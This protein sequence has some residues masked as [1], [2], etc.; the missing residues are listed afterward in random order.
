VIKNGDLNF[1][2]W[3]DFFKDIPFTFFRTSIIQEKYI[4]TILDEVNN[5]R[6]VNSDKKIKI[7]EIAGGSG[8]TSAVLQDLLKDKNV[9]VYYSDLSENLC[10]TV[11]AKFGLTTLTVDSENILYEEN[12]FDIIF[13]QGFLEHFSNEQIKRFLF[14]QS[15]VSDVIIFDIPNDKRTS[16]IQEFGNERFLSNQEWKQLIWESGLSEVYMTARRFSNAWKKYIPKIIYDSEWF[17]KLFGESSIF[18]CRKYN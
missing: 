4:N 1:K 13:H 2:D 5:I 12:S 18:V 15:R 8:Y 7:L 3:D 17:G 9:E 11:A 10:K 16:K 14:E 6:N